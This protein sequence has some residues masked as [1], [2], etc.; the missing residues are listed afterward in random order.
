MGKQIRVYEIYPLGSG[1]TTKSVYYKGEIV[2]V[3]AVSIK[4]AYYFAAND[5]WA[6]VDAEQPTG[7]IWKYSKD[8]GWYQVRPDKWTNQW[9]PRHTDGVRTIRSFLKEV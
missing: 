7:I 3:A 5:E 9:I 2:A 1:F 6:A 4:Q 8:N